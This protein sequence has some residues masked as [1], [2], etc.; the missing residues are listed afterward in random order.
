MII[1]D[2]CGVKP[3][4]APILSTIAQVEK[5]CSRTFP[6]HPE[7]NSNAEVPVSYST[8]SDSLTKVDDLTVSEIRE[9]SYN[10]AV[11]LNLCSPQNQTKMIELEEKSPSTTKD[12]DCDI[13][14]EKPLSSQQVSNTETNTTFS[15]TIEKEERL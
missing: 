6:K 12:I 2:L 5:T 3:D 1:A 13:E 15:I 11:V 10:A 9:E 7:T 8:A 14:D 4:I